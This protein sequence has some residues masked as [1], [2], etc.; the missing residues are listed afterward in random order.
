MAAVEFVVTHVMAMETGSPVAYMRV[1][2]G[3]VILG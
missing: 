1:E 2:E 3:F